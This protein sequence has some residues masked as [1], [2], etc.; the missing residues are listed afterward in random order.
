MEPGF[1]NQKKGLCFWT[2]SLLGDLMTKKRV[3]EILRAVNGDD[4][5]QHLASIM[6]EKAG[7]GKDSKE[8]L[9]LFTILFLFNHT[10]CIG[11]FIKQDL[12]DEDLP[13]LHGKEG[14]LTIPTKEG[15]T[16]QACCTDWR[17]F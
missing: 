17:F 8:C 4:G 13:L 1:D 5:E 6:P 7:I 16:V 14:R 11:E 9:K 12:C 10:K 15:K 3:G 2:S